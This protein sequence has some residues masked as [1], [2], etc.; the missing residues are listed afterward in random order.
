MTH[1]KRVPVTG[2]TAPKSPFGGTS[3]HDA[4]TLPAYIDKLK[5]SIAV[6]R[7]KRIVINQRS[8]LSTVLPLLSSL[9]E[10]EGLSCYSAPLTDADIQEIL[11]GT[12]VTNLSIG[13]VKLPRTELRWLNQEGIKFLLVRRTNFSNPAIANLPLSVQHFNAERTRIN[14]DGLDSFVRL[15]NL[16]SLKLKRTP[17]TAA[18]IEDLRQKMP[19]C[20]IEWAPLKRP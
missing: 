2:P 20:K 13:E 6:R 11:R 17:C 19:W 7:I 15:T 16:T 12:H 4:S 1:Y 3:Y 14:D 18:G 8:N 5:L 9:E 10:L